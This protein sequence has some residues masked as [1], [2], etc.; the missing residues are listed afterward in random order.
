MTNSTKYNPRDCYFALWRYKDQRNI[1][2]TLIAQQVWDE[3]KGT[4]HM[5]R[6]HNLEPLLKNHGFKLA[7]SNTW[8]SPTDMTSTE[9][10]GILET[11]GFTRNYG[12]EGFCTGEGARFDAKRSTLAPINPELS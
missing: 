10:V 9:V 8:Q 4:R 2:F 1:Y 12:L 5:T 7:S 6:M 3:T 11:L